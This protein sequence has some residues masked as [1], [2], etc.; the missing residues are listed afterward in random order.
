MTVENIKNAIIGDA[1]KEADRIRQA[2]S[3]KADE[4]FRRAQQRLQRDFERR[5]AEAEQ[6]EQDKKNRSIIALRSALGMELLSAK[7]AAIDQVFDEAVAKLVG[8]PSG[9]YKV[10]LLKWLG[11]AALDDPAELVLNASDRE[12]LGR[13]LADLAN[14]GRDA[15]AAI[16]L[17]EESAEISGGFV[18]RTERYEIDRSLDSIIAN[19]KEDMAPEIASELFAGRVERL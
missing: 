2:G 5:M 10:L 14:K 6:H 9:G 8:L 11:K 18:L 17:A 19:L 3:K 13:E 1:E 15:A 7:N 4:K 12:A 16:T